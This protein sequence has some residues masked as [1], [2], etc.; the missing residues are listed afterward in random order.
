MRSLVPM[1][2]PLVTLLAAALLVPARAG[3]L[4]PCTNE[5][6]ACILRRLLSHGLIRDDMS[7]YYVLARKYILINGNIPM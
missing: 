6:T 7:K 2:R 3:P 5:D 1:M 4:A